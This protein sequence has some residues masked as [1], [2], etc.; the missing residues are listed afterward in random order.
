[1]GPSTAKFLLSELRGFGYL[2][3]KRSQR[4]ACLRELIEEDRLKRTVVDSVEYL[5]L[6]EKKKRREQPSQV[7][8]LAPFDPLVRNRERFEHLWGWEYRFEAYTPRPRRKIGYYAMPVLWKDQVIGWANVS[9]ETDHVSFA[10]GYASSRPDE[11][12][13]T[14][15]AEAE[16]RRMTR[17]LGLESGHCKLSL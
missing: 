14:Q 5:S 7:R 4:L 10:F 3:K 1:M 2:L 13:F 6:K 11:V 9:R 8:L 15:E 12:E 17:F 16:A